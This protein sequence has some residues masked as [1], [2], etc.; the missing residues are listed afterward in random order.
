MKAMNFRVL[1][2]C[3]LAS[4]SSDIQINEL[5]RRIKSYET[6][7]THPDRLLDEKK[8]NKQT[9]QPKMR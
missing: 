5:T 3:D 8:T 1:F 2:F 7:A 9:N 6:T 4:I